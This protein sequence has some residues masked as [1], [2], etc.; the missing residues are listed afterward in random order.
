MKPLPI[1]CIF[2]LLTTALHAQC[3]PGDVLLNGQ[4]EVDN[5]L[6]EYPNCTEIQGNL[7]V[8]NALGDDVNSLMPLA[9]IRKVGGNFSLISTY[10][11]LAPLN[12]DSILGDFNLGGFSDDLSGYDKLK[13]IGGSLTVNADNYTDLR[14]LENIDT[15][16][17]NLAIRNANALRSLEGLDNLRWVGGDFWITDNESLPDLQ[18]LAALRVIRGDVVVRENDVLASFEGLSQLEEIGGTMEIRESPALIS[19]RGMEQVQRIGRIELYAGNGFKNFEGLSALE[20]IDS[21]LFI[22]NNDDLENFVGLSSLKHAYAIR[23]H[24]CEKLAN[25]EGLMAPELEVNTIYLWGLRGLA[26]LHGLQGVKDIGASLNII[27]CNN[28]LTLDGLSLGDSIRGSLVFSENQRLADVGALQNVQYIGGDLF[29]DRLSQLEQMPPLQLRQVGGNFGLEALGKLYSQDG[30]AQLATVGGGLVLSALDSLRTLDFLSGL[31]YVGG[32][33]TIAYNGTLADIEG[34]VNTFVAGNLNIA[35]NDSLSFCAVASVCAKLAQQPASV[36][37][38]GNGDGCRDAEE[39]ETLCDYGLS[40]IEV[41]YDQNGNGQKDSGDRAVRIGQFVV[42][43]AYILFTP[44]GGQLVVLPPDSASRKIVYQHPGQWALTTGNDTLLFEPGDLPRLFYIG[45]TPAGEPQ[46]QLDYTLSSNPAVCDREVRFYIN[47]QNTGTAIADPAFCF[48]Y[49]G[50]LLSFI[51]GD[52]I[53][54]NT[55]CPTGDAT[56]ELY[57]GD[58]LSVEALIGL[59]GVEAIG[60]T[61]HF[62]INRRDNLDSTL[63]LYEPILRCAFDPNDKLASPSGRPEEA[64]IPPDTPIDYTIRFQNTGNFPAEDVVLADTLSVYLDLSTFQLLGASHPLSEIRLEG[65]ALHFSFLGINL[66]DSISNEAGSHGF[67]Q[68]RLWQM[69]GLAHETLIRNSAAIYFDQNPPI[70][71]NMV[72]RMVFDPALGVEETEVEESRLRLYPNPTDGFLYFRAAFSP[73]HY[74]LFNSNGQ[75]VGQ[76]AARGNRIDVSGLPGGFYGVA[77]WGGG[78]VCWGAFVRG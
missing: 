71:T 67:V 50:E 21:D 47:V 11:S 22:T 31:E 23:I 49:S 16:Y 20:T 13:Y 34:L 38:S 3:P 29:W 5:F 57:P 27:S 4:L 54:E 17:G 26:N 24:F 60:D 75:M 74:Y 63:Y 69:P 53:A 30:F 77:F 32:T 56:G 59:P 70:F 18:G 48:R 62:S 58:L 65:N 35:Y 64:R 8:R 19:F 45:I 73:T 66:P 46:E 12:I 9:N 40:V 68:F 72:D 25:M 37:I 78:E 42:D 1:A 2:S 55:I 6:A 14:G 52:S 44:P 43:G 51:P 28:L 7:E 15:L 36:L 33:L 39:V 76:G 10:G 41:F 61:L